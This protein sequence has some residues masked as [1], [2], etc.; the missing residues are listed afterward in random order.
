LF[1]FFF[2]PRCRYFNGIGNILSKAMTHSILSL[3]WFRYDKI[4]CPRLK[5]RLLFFGLPKIT[6]SMPSSSYV[7]R[8]QK[9]IVRPNLLLILSMYFSIILRGKIF[10]YNHED[11]KPRIENEFAIKLIQWLPIYHKPLGL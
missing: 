7:L 11:N 5:V 1:C 4:Y 6:V 8:N 9:K 10:Y 2:S 3:N